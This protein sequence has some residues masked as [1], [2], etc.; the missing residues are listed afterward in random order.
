ML[1]TE[2]VTSADGTK[3][4]ADTI[5]AGP[6]LVLVGGAFSFRRWRGFIELASILS[7]S[8]T[9]YSYDRRGRGDSAA[10]PDTTVE[11]EI[12]DLAAVVNHSGGAAHIFGMSSGGVLSLRAIA[13]GVPARTVTVYQPPFVVS[14]SGKTPPI[15]FGNRLADLIAQ[16]RRGAAVH[17]FMTRGMGVP[18]PV[19]VM[20]RLAPVW[21]DLKA[22]AHTLPADH[23]ILGDTLAGRPLASQ[24]WSDITTPTLVLDGSKSP[25]T[26]AL[27]ADELASRLPAGARSTLAGQG[28]NV[29][30][31]ALGHAIRDFATSIDST[32][33]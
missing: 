19:V 28:H 32:L 27:A 1:T 12:D 29:S 14:A 8:F 25:K 15:D 13:A 5:G 2:T 11:L 10:G 18:A 24:P 21:K 23:A 22:L 26:V 17:Y 16:G 33:D 30:M 6:P 31:A 3:I 4:A 7:G 9:V 20:M